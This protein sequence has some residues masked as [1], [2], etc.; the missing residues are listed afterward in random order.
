MVDHIWP[1]RLGGTDHPCNLQAACRRCNAKKYNHRPLGVLPLFSTSGGELVPA[2][3]GPKPWHLR[4]KDG[5]NAAGL[6]R[7][8]IYDIRTATE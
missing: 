8:A 4:R 3:G 7:T 2:C 5:A 6:S 1:R